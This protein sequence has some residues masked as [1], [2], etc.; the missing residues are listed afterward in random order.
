MN[1]FTAL[2][3]LL[4]VRRPT[5]ISIAC[6]KHD[7][8]RYFMRSFRINLSFYSFYTIQ[9]TLYDESKPTKSVLCEWRFHKDW[10]S[11]IHWKFLL[12]CSAIGWFIKFL[13]WSL[14]KLFKFSRMRSVPSIQICSWTMYR[15]F[16][17]FMDLLQNCIMLKRLHQ[18]DSILLSSLLSGQYFH[19]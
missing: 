1:L 6:K 3:Y 7:S 13:I 16:W 5:T 14:L 2:W 11:L 12:L 4:L 19:V 18:I 8:Y 17:G 15:Y 10:S 9:F